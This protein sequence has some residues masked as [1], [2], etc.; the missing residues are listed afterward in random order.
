MK[1]VVI[2]IV[3]ALVLI[4]GGF[5]TL[6]YLKHKEEEYKGIFYEEK[7]GNYFIHYLYYSRRVFYNGILKTERKK[8]NFL[9][10]T[11]GKSNKVYSL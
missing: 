10:S 6:E 4:A 2:L 3:S 8:R 1:K 7:I 5:F 9:E 11:R